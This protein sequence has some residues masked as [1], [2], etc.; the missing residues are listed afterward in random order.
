MT[1]IGTAKWLPSPF[2]TTG[3][4]GS[5]IT[6]IV[7]HWM[8]GTLANT[9]AEFARG[10]R[11]VSAHYG[12]EDTTVHQYVKDADTAWHAGNWAENRRSIGI[13]HSAGP[14]RPASALTIATSISLMV[15]LCR[16]HNISP[17]HIYPHKKFYPTACPGTLPIAA[18]IAAV[19][20]QLAQPTPTTPEVDMPLTEAEIHAIATD[21]WQRF[22]IH[23]PNG[24]LV[25][26][27]DTLARLLAA[28]TTKGTP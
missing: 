16:K 22:K 13:E 15:D 27:A 6:D 8:A 11:R 19:R 12:V 2:H 18:M 5:P 3:R 26:L 4:Q 21:V 23:G 20:A 25:S 7:L 17:D 14:K 10:S 1:I 28:T 24:E 9:D